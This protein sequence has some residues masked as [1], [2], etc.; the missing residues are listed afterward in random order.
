[1]QILGH[2]LPM[3]TTVPMDRLFTPRTAWLLVIYGVGIAPFFEEFFF[4]GLIYPSLRASFAEG[5]GAEEL[6]AWRPLVRLGAA[7]GM[8]A[9]AYWRLRQDVMGLTAGRGEV[10]GL[11]VAL[12]AL[13]ILLV[14][15]G[16]LLGV[17]GWAI[18]HMARWKQEELL[19]ILITGL[20]FGMMHAAQLGWAWAAVLILVLVGVILTAVRAR[21]GSLMS[22]WLMH[23]AYNGT[24]FALQYIATRGFHHFS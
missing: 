23:C 4:R 17:A 19:A 22:S 18:N 16:L 9:I 8:A 3:P 10:A 13:A 5:M 1:V 12:I 14:F 7:L 15:P 24:L 20:L 2:L 21:T 6:R 11:G